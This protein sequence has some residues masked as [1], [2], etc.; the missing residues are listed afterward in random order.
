[1]P[2]PTVKEET[3]DR[4]A[5]LVDRKADVPASILTFEQ[6]LNYLLDHVDDLD[7]RVKELEESSARGGLNQPTTSSNRFR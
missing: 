6:Q 1:M 4:L 3:R 7:G 2:R 5:D